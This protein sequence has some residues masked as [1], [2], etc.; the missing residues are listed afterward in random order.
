MSSCYVTKKEASEIL[1]V[2]VRQIDYYLADGAL[3]VDHMYKNR[4]MIKISEV[5]A[6]REQKRGGK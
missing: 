1:G 5:F 2:T 3:H 4:V 6:L